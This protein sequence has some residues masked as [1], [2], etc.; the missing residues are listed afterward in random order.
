MKDR[1]GYGTVGAGSIGIRAALMHLAGRASVFLPI[2]SDLI[3]ICY[4][5]T[6]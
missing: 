5:R 4:I 1:V 2:S 3:K 6:Q